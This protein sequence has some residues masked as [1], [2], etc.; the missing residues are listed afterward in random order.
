MSLVRR[1]A[2]LPLFD[3][4]SSQ[5]RR[6]ISLW[7]CVLAFC[8]GTFL[9]FTLAVMGGALRPLDLAFSLTLQGIWWPPAWSLFEAIAVLGGVELTG[10]AAVSLFLF[11][12]WKRQWREATA[13]L[14]LPGAFLAEAITKVVVNHPQPPVTHAGRLSVTTLLQGQVNSYPSGHMVRSMIVYGLAAVF[15]TRFG[16]KERIKRAAPALV[17]VLIAAVGF[18]RLYLGV[19]WASDVIGGFLLGG[20]FFASAMLWMTH[21][22]A[23]RSSTRSRHSSVG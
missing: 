3:N 4:A 7:G 18:D 6:W 19:H 17:A 22:K 23:P 15:I 20:V 9:I 21:A 8:C 14:A 16:R 1:T 12:V 5:R 11:L 2:K 10:V 13:L